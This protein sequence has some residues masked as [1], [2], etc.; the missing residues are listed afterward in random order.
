MAKKIETTIK[1][2]GVE[3]N[4]KEKGGFATIAFVP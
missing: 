4:I 2:N 3:E 1:I